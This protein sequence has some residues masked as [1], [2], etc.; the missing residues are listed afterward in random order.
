[1]QNGA[2]LRQLERNIIASFEKIP[3]SYDPVEWIHSA[4]FR[5][6]LDAWRDF[7]GYYR[8]H[9]T[10][11]TV[12]TVDT[13]AIRTYVRV[14][15]LLHKLIDIGHDNPLTVTGEQPQAETW[16]DKAQ[17]ALTELEGYLDEVT[18]AAYNRIVSEKRVTKTD[19]ERSTQG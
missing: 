15:R 18:G 17:Q 10:D 8:A 7:A 4:E 11:E 1:M 16:H 12:R 2:E 3:F 9:Q 5:Q 6:F 14:A 19:D 13:L